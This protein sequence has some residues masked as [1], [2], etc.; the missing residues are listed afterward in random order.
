MDRQMTSVTALWQQCEFQFDDSIAQMQ[1]IIDQSPNEI[2][3]HVLLQQ[4]VEFREYT[5]DQ[6]AL[7]VPCDTEVPYN[8]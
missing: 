6:Q 7:H 4:L 2:S 5:R 3:W 1:A 8:A